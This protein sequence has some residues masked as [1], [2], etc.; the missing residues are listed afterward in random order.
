MIIPVP[1]SDW[2]GAAPPHPVQGM[3]TLRHWAPHP[4]RV[5]IPMQMIPCSI[6]QRSGSG[7]ISCTRWMPDIFL[8]S[9]L[10]GHSSHT[11]GKGASTEPLGGSSLFRMASR[12]LL[13]RATGGGHPGR[14]IVHLDGLAQRLDGVVEDR[15]VEGAFLHVGLWLRDDASLGPLAVVAG[16]PVPVCPWHR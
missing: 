10:R 8:F 13:M 14:I 12:A 4:L 16:R 9:R 1:M 15:Y 7:M 2:F 6:R 5:A 3:S 11:A